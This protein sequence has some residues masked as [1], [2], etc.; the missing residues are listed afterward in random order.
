M[1]LPCPKPQVGCEMWWVEQWTYIT[2]LL[3]GLIPCQTKS[4]ITHWKHLFGPRG[5]SPVSTGTFPQAPCFLLVLLDDSACGT[6]TCPEICI[7][8]SSNSEV[9]WIPMCW[10]PP[11]PFPQGPVVD[12][13]GCQWCLGPCVWTPDPH[14]RPFIGLAWDSL[15]GTYWQELELTAWKGSVCFCSVL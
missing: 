14:F 1:C 12:G 4:S 13:R 9:S 3:P 7:L 11:T 10:P 2:R 8:P 6:F 5:W 15:I